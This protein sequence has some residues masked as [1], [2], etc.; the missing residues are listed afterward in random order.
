LSPTRRRAI[1]ARLVALATPTRRVEG[2][3][4][5]SVL[6]NVATSL[7]ARVYDV[8]L[9]AFS[10][11]VASSPRRSFMRASTSTPSRAVASTSARID[12]RRRV[13]A[14][15]S[16]S[17]DDAVDVE[18]EWG[19]T[20]YDLSKRWPLINALYDLEV[21][22]AG[23]DPARYRLGWHGA[24]SYVGITYLYDDERT[25]EARGDVFVSK[26]LAL[27]PEFGNAVG[28]VRHELA[29][30]LAGPTSVDHG[31]EFLRA[32][33]TLDVPAA[34]REEKTGA[35]YS[36]PAT[37]LMW[38]KC[39]A[40][41]MLR[42]KSEVLPELLFER[43]VWDAPVNGNRTVF[44]DDESGVVLDAFEMY[45]LVRAEEEATSKR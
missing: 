39:D 38:A 21:R 20:S 41:E 37:Q 22:R 40:E 9:G 25:G 43:N 19:S 15:A 6:I 28:C 11:L 1:R 31:V 14:R 8:P 33:E 16:S 18:R 2:S 34:W 17:I 35:F 3:S 29:H 10:S 26:Y 44:K 42:G 32:C 24:K 27:D 36:R 7:T 4:L 12:R 45:D 23:L 30:A 5:V 13:R